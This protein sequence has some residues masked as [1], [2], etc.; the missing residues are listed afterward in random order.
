ML[1]LFH[2]PAPRIETIDGLRTHLQIAIE[3][4]HAT[5]P[6][7][8]C[9]LYTIRDG[10]N[11]EA[12]RVIRSVV[13]E[14]M[15]HMALAANV[16]NAIGGAP[17]LNHPTFVPQ[18]PASLPDSDGHLVLHL[19]KF[20]RRAVETF[21][22]I[23]RPAKPGARPEPDR[24]HTIGQFYQA[25]M[26]GLK[27][28]CRKDQYFTGDPARQVGPEAYYGGGGELF[29][30]RDLHSAV[31]AL[32]VIVNEGEGLPHSIFDSKRKLFQTVRVPAHYFRFK[33]LLAGRYFG[34][35]DTPATGP[36]GPLM[37]VDWDAAYDM[38]PNPKA[39]DHPPGSELHQRAVE[40]NRAYT[41]LLGVLHRA[42]NGK[43]KRLA[44]AVGRMY[45]LKYQA[46]ALVRTPRED[47]RGNA[48]PGFQ[49]DPGPARSKASRSK[50]LGKAR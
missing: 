13:M 12:A 43:P 38:A 28:V 25:I 23:E 17:S 50:S 27:R 7:Y 26:D 39:E 18:Y 22:A 35:N 21:Q 37:P 4:E 19:A 9:G 34:P 14:E 30:V 44:D 42:F 40:F 31:R 29:C 47:G 5:I 24:Y 36:T 11:A 6:V 41:G 10:A 8:L 48:G 15:L 46:Q 45:E 16:L 33:E 32:K 1:H 3:L 2:R 20:S 49:F